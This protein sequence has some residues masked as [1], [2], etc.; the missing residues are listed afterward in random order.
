[1]LEFEFNGLAGNIFMIVSSCDQSVM[2]TGYYFIITVNSTTFEHSNVC[3][4]FTFNN[5]NLIYT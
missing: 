5:T 3:Y 1:M 2:L 4:S